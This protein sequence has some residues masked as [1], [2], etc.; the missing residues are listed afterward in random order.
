MA[1][2]KIL[3]PYN[4]TSNDEKSIDFVIQSFGQDKDAEI[5]LFHAYIPVPNIEVSDKTVMTRLAGN[6]AYLRQKSYELKAEIEKAKDRLIE[7]GFLSDKVHYV[8]K[9]QEREAAQ[10]IIDH[11]HEGEFTA[12][13]LNRNPSKIR[14]FFTASISKKVSKALKDLDLYMVH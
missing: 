12:I 7:A 6:L 11:A 2:L 1:N 5:T 3:V 13:V 8:F 4:F 10:E 14:K 9:P